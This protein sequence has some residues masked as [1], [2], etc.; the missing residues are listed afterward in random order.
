MGMSDF[1]GETDEDEAIATIHRALDLGVTLLDT[2]DMYGPFTN[3][4]L[5]GRAIHGRRDQVVLATKFGNGAVPTA[6]GSASAAGPI[7][8]GGLRRLA[9]AARRRRIDLYYQHRVD[10]TVP[11]RRP[12]APWPSSCGRARS[13]TWGSRR[14]A[15][16]H[17]PGPR[18]PPHLRAADRY[19]LWTREP[20]AELLRPC[21]SSASA[22]SPTARWVAGSSTGRFRTERPAGPATTAAASRVPG[23]E[24]RR[25]LRHRGPV[26]DR[27]DG[28]D[29][30]PARPGLGAGP[31]AGLVPSPGPTGPVPGENVAAAAV[32]LLA[33]D[34]PEAA[35]RGGAAPAPPPATR[36]ADMSTVERLSG[37]CGPRVSVLV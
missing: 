32:T 3:E 19:S 28:R 4:L 21:A 23:R 34:L 7:R 13:A 37:S 22:S 14:R 24:L 9:R 35:R 29:A 12:S 30:R 5:V 11:S 26:G 31:G 16:D 25:N 1:Y 15:G 2:A 18:G 10:P 6:A 33:G 17:P 27:P 20:E 36:Y 8:A